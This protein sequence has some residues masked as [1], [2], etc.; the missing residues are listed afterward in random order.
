MKGGTWL[1]ASK[2]RSAILTLIFHHLVLNL[3]SNRKIVLT[4]SFPQHKSF[5][6]V[7]KMI[8]AHSFLSEYLVQNKYAAA[9]KVTI[10][11]GSNGGARSSPC[12]KMEV[13][14]HSLRPGLLVAACINCAPEDTFGCAVA[15]VSVYDLL[16]VR[17]FFTASANCL[18]YRVVPQ[19][20][21]RFV[22][23]DLI[24]WTQLTV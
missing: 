16:K 1:V 7:S 2:I 23:C 11:G 17:P 6:H 12:L 18:T 10:N 24:V 13:L 9:G 5:L 4:I 14:S 8:A 22:V 19:I 21:N 20:H 3:F 15:E